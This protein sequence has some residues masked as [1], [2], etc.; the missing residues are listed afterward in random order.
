MI[1][2]LPGISAATTVRLHT[3][4]GIIDVELF[5]TAAPQT[6]ANFMNYVNSGKYVN[7]FVHRSVPGFVIQG[8]GFSWDSTRSA[9]GTIVTN[10]PVVN[11][12]SPSRSNLRG[13]IAMAKLSGDPNSA[14]SQW[15]FN[16]ANNNNPADPNS[17]DNQNGGFT[18]FGQVKGNGM[19]VVD[20][21]AA[22][23]LAN[24]GGAFTSLPLAKPLT[25]NSIQTQN[26][27]LVN[28]VSSLIRPSALSDSDR[29]FAY[30]E[31]VYPQFVSPASAIN[32]V[33]GSAQGYYYRFYPATN[34]YVGTANGILYYLGPASGSQILA[35]GTLASWL[36][37]AAAAGS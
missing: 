16:L 13:T 1:F 21:I 8:G 19:Q 12:F 31:S 25:G 4:L 6:V 27:V 5:D 23:P 14:T 22:L 33:S 10:P 32:A 26:L 30:L 7:S 2:A 37:T 15:F 29:V 11:E 35:M 20:A 18:V 36:A 9:V 24:A 3:T 17:L 28:T 34:A